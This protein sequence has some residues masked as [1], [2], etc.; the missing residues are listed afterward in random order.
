MEPPSRVQNGCRVCGE[1]LSRYKVSYD[2]H[3][4]K[5]EEKLQSIGVFVGSD[6]SDIHPQR[7]CHGCYN[8]CM[9]TMKAKEEGRD[10]TA[11]LNQFD[12]GH[13]ESSCEESGM[14]GRKRKKGTSWEAVKQHFSTGQRNQRE[15]TTGSIS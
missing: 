8:V 11:R 5:N 2:C 14:V 6:Q 12:W 3:T 1:K 9:R 13:V 10:Y 7:F 4:A 15:G